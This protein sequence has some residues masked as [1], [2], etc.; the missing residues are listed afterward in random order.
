M[1]D[2]RVTNNNVKWQQ[3][4]STRYPKRPLQAEEYWLLG[5]PTPIGLIILNIE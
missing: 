5:K 3:H 4:F 1:L 2:M